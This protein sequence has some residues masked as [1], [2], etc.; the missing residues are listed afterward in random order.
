[1]TTQKTLTVLAAIAIV[2][3]AGPAPAA[4]VIVGPGVRNGN[5]NDDTS[6]TDNRS[7]AQTPF[8]ENIGTGGQS[9]Q[10]TRTTMPYDGSR[11][12]VLSEKAA[13]QAAQDTGYTI[14]DGD[15]FDVSY[16]WRDASNW[17]DGN[18]R[19]AIKLFTTDTDLIGGTQTTFAT[20]LSATSTSNNTYEAASDSVAATGA[21]TGKR[22]FVAIDSKNGG[23]GADG[24][25]RVDNFQLGVTA[26]PAPVP[27]L[28]ADFDGSPLRT[29]G[30]AI[31]AAHLD[32][33]TVGGA[34]TV[35]DDEES[36]IGAED[37][38]ASNHALAGDRG[39]YDF[40]LALSGGALSL[41][42]DPIVVSFDSQIIRT[43]GSGNAKKNLVTGWDSSSN[44]VFRVVLTTDGSGGGTPQGRLKYINQSGNEVTLINNLPSVGG[45][46]TTFDVNELTNL[47][48]EM[49]AATMDIY[50]NG[51]LEAHNVAYRTAGVTDLASF[52]LGGTGGGNASASGAW[53][54]NIQVSVLSPI[55]EPATMIALFA[56]V[57]G[58]G[59]YV[60]KRR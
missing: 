11:N 12:H 45:T 25:A 33:G 30:Q 14:A 28:L 10:A 3:A 5:F 32:A 2:L 13:R 35:N 18:D 48:I 27:V 53:Y 39:S 22:L 20:L 50:V 47:Y 8:W 57:A 34:W 7:F 9:T 23:G 29:A 46:P 24:F 40:D 36:L 44:Q 58:L 37:S 15:V 6:G 52:T 38:D 1:M 26:R 21:Q 49:G 55:P 41:A 42:G 43:A 19:I 16:V 56:G 60:R 31:T 4:T 59:G 54:D 51:V 17:N